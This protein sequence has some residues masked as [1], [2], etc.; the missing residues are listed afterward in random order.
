ML[1]FK[2]INIRKKII[3]KKLYKALLISTKKKKKRLNAH[4]IQFRSNRIL[5]L[6]TKFKFLGTRIYGPIPKEVRYCLKS[7]RYKKIISY[8][9]GT[10]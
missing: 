2:K 4:F 6:D 5:L 1:S 9:Q 8:S 7:F 3:K 10:V